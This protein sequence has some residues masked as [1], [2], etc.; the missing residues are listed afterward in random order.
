MT[1]EEHAK[2]QEFRGLMEKL[3]ATRAAILGASEGRANTSGVTVCPVDGGELRYRVS[4]TGLIWGKC[5][6]P[7][8]V[9]WA[10]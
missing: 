3:G 2:N 4:R 9:R 5:D 1:A 7:G 10:E 6:V 8:C